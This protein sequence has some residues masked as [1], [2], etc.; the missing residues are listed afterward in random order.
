MKPAISV[1]IPVYKCEK[2]LSA[3]IDSVLNQTFQDFELILVDDGSPDDSPAICD[4]YAKKDDRVKVIHK[5]NGGVSSARNAGIE[6]AKG[7]YITFI[8]SDDYIDSEML[9][10]LYEQI[11]AQDGDL[12]ISGLR[13]VF[14]DTKEKKEYHLRNI[15]FQTSEID[16][17]YEE[18]DCNF[19]FSAIYAKLYKR[20]IIKSNSV[21]YAEGFSILEDG[22]FVLE[23]LKHCSNCILFE[24]VFYNYRQ[25]NEM[26]LMKAF[27]AN[28]IQALEHYCKVGAWLENSLRKENKEKYYIKLYSLLY[29][30]L[31]Q[32]FTRAKLSRK[33]K[34]KLVK[35]YLMSPVTREIIKNVK[36]SALGIKQRI[37]ARLIKWKWSGFI[38]YI[39]TFHFGKSEKE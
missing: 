28:A 13:Y 29:S 37:I 19:G 33:E 21:F 18:I 24:G 31:I 5:E 11:K 34:K 6:A 14:E 32:I 16:S 22:S 2:Y 15:K 9:K 38:Y 25:A 12:I 35:T 30:F 8:D 17:V 20:E 36:F 1:I 7:E 39:F 4:D 27:N 3:C 23:Y 26:S 10:S